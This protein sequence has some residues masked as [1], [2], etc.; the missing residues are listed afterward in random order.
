[1]R[2]ERRGPVDYSYQPL[3][4]AETLLV[5]HVVVRTGPPCPIHWIGNIFHRHVEAG[6]LDP[7]TINW[8]SPGF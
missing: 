7:G 5:Y 8:H 2:A 6:G 4:T 3:K 1:M